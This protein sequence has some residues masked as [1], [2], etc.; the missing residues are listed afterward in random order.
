M[1]IIKKTVLALIILLLLVMCF[2]SFIYKG[3]RSSLQPT[4]S[5]SQAEQIEQGRYLAYAGDCAAC[6]TLKGGEGAIQVYAGGL[7]LETP[8][9]HIYG[10]NIT[11][12]KTT[13]I[14]EYTLQDFDNAL[15]YGVRKDGASLYP[16]MPYPSFARTNDED[17][18][19]LYAYFMHGVAPI[20]Q[21]NKK[22]DIIWPLSMRWPL[23]GWRMVFFLGVP[24]GH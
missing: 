21:A 22:S 24:E 11:P 5:T 4:L 8:L 16:A 7:P 19:A 20:E 9:G 18:Q 15:R 12:D 3:P 13:G 6:H 17:V 2:F 23:A 14:G 1:K 10:T